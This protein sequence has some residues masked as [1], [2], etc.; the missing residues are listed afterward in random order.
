MRA[1]SA[2][3]A[4]VQTGLARVVL[5]T[6]GKGL[7]GFAIATGCLRGG[8]VVTGRERGVLGDGSGEG[9]AC[10]NGIGGWGAE[11]KL[12]G[13]C[14]GGIGG[15]GAECKLRSGDR[16]TRGARM[17]PGVLKWIVP[18]GSDVVV[19]VDV[20]AVVSVTVTVR[21]A[22]AV[23]PPSKTLSPATV[24]DKPALRACLLTLEQCN[25]H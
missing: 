22:S 2:W 5:A 18:I 12:G 23:S 14:A 21:R 19:V 16:S 8:G 4:V 25:W 20:V 7:L 10:A 1:A 24:S 11:S 6:L 17:R 13:A 15:W 9:G 3:E